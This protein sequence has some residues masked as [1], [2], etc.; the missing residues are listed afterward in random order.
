MNFPVH[1][2]ARQVLDD[3]AA[4]GTPPVSEQT[5]QEVR[6]G[7]EA[8]QETRP[9]GPAVESIRDIVIPGQAGGIPARVYQPVANPPGVVVFYHGGGWVIGSLDSF[10]PAC[11]ALSVASGCTL[12]S[13]G[14]RL[15]PE[16]Q[17]PA[18]AD[19]AYDA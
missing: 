7:F 15:A 5:P 17:F 18:A 13:V 3:R 2:Q 19:D 4:A 6:A 12:V 16:H 11:R 10:D 1:P 8:E 14:Y 9:P